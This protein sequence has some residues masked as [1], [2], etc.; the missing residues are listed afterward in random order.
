MFW[1]FYPETGE[2]FPGVADGFETVEAAVGYWQNNRP[3]WVWLNTGNDD[4]NLATFL[5]PA[6]G[7][8]VVVREIV[9]DEK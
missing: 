2:R 1:F 4:V 7:T 5:H 3:A 9:E 6:V 8:V